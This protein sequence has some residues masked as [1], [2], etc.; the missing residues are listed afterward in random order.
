MHQ[1]RFRHSPSS[2]QNHA[3]STFV[4]IALKQYFCIRTH[5][6]HSL[7]IEYEDLEHI[8]LPSAT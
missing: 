3:A 8:V 6:S 1:L 5:S 2:N 7:L 4:G